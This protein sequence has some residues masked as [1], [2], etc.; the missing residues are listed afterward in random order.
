MMIVENLHILP[1]GCYDIL[2]GMDCLCK[3]KVTLKC[4]T[5]TFTCEYEKGNVRVVHGIPHT[6]SIRQASTLLLK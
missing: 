4:Y 5:K 3:N 2:I 6:T 1:L